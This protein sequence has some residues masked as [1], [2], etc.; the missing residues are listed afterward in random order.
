MQANDCDANASFNSNDMV[1]EEDLYVAKLNN[2]AQIIWSKQL[3]VTTSSPKNCFVKGI[4]VDSNN[5]IYITGG[6]HANFDGNSRVDSREETDNIIVKF[7]YGF[8]IGA[9]LPLALGL[10]LFIIICLPQ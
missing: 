9:A 10:N 5:N 3:G 8:L 2:E 6:T 4:S 7:E 1:G